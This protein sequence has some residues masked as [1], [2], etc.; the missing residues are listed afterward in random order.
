MK[1][2]LAVIVLVAVTTGN[3][4]AQCVFVNNEI[5]NTGDPGC[6]DRMLTYTE[7]AS[8]TNLIP[9]GYPVPMPVSSLAPI[10]GFRTY[11]SLLALHQDMA[12]TDPNVA[13]A[14]VGNTLAGRSIWS[15]SIGDADAMTIDG[16]TEPAVMA[17]GGTHAR[18]WQ[19]PEAVSAVLETLA[20][21]ANDGWL[22]SYLR[23][24]LNVVLIPVLNV[25]G[26]LQTQ[27]HP[28]R[29]SADPQQPR[30][31][32]MRR[33]NLR[34]PG[35]NL[36]IDDTI[37][38]TAD[39]FW[40]VDLNRNSPQGWGLNG[41]S[42]TQVTSLVYRGPAASSEP[43][44]QALQN[45]AQQIPGK[46]LRLFMDVHS[47]SQIYFVPST[48]NAR[49]DA[50]TSE[51]GA[52][53]RA[54]HNFKYAYSAD[55][56]NGGFGLIADWFAHSFEIPAWTLETEPLNGGQDYGGTAQHGHSG[57][58]LPDS[59]VARM[60][61]EIVATS[62]IGFYRQSGP[63]YVTAVRIRDMDTGTLRY[64]AEWQPGNRRS[65]Q[66]SQNDAL[67]PGGNYRLWV[68]FSKPMRFRTQSGDAGT[69]PGQRAGPGSGR[70]DL[71]V[72][73]LSA[74]NDVTLTTGGISWPDQPDGTTDGYRRYLFDA[75]TMGFTI[76]AGMP[77]N[78]S[79][80]AV[81]ELSFADM[82]DFQVDADPATPVDWQNGS[83]SAYENENGAS[84][85]SGGIDCQFNPFIATDPTA[86]APPVGADCRSMAAPPPP[87]PPP[88]PQTPS[89]G[90][91]GTGIDLLLLLLAAA[92][93]R[94][95]N[96]R[97]STN[98]HQD[99]PHTV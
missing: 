72:P 35:T 77:V 14:I 49:R 84:T 93:I 20:A 90:G 78:G 47:F 32:R 19:P 12:I 44:V 50:Y 71:Q 10:D 64:S 37:D 11:D 91:G 45:A 86:V 41:G 2:L 70:A 89:S 99:R 48:G 24:N 23:D 95:L 65:L 1:P 85:D 52:V 3:A 33:R 96:F 28:A 27:A 55:S 66:V 46:R 94:R 56:P 5:T 31:G 36:P 79:T 73:S 9:L 25:D 30:E 68:A 42:S 58:I 59:E 76:P 43:E 63:P 22:G 69:Y 82:S 83:W 13:A 4:R 61:D 80:A 57:F 53:M 54:V 8:G 34:N 81:L 6:S 74:A 21:T 7:S 51:L 18:E 26:F 60:R 75:A 87:P 40:G 16:L 67:V 38:T 29:T 62:L 98:R 17:I 15:Y 97:I 88:P 39:N 92:A